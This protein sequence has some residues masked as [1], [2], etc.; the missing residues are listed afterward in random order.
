MNPHQAPFSSSARALPPHGRPARRAARARGRVRLLGTAT[1]LTVLWVTPALAHLSIIRQ[2]P[3]S[4]GSI[5]AG[6]RF[7]AALAAGDF[8]GDGFDDIAMGSPTEDV[9]ALADAGAVVV[10]YGAQYGI[11]HVGSQLFTPS[12]IGQTDQAGARFGAALATGDFNHDGYDDLVVGSPF[13]DVGGVADAGRIY[14]VYGSAGGLQSTSIV[15]DQTTGNG[16][17]ETGDHFG[18]SFAVG[19]FDGD[20]VGYDDLA[21]GAPGEDAGAGAVFVNYLG[22]FLGLTN[23][24]ATY[25]KQSSLGGTDSPGDQFGFAL[26]AGNLFGTSHDDLA[27]G[28][29]YKTI[30]V[31]GFGY[32]GAGAVWVLRGSDSGI[33]TSSPLTCDAATVGP[34]QNGANFGYALAVGQFFAGSTRS[35]AVAEPGRMVNGLAN[36]GRVLVVEG[37]ASALDWANARILT[38]DSGGAAVVQAGDRFGS[39]L[40]AGD[41]YDADGYDDLGIGSPDDGFGVTT[42]AGQFHIYPGGS[43]G[44]S[45]A[46]WSAFNQGTLNEP[47]EANDEF[48]AAVAYGHFDQGGRGGFAV[49]APGERYENPAEGATTYDDA[50]QVHMILPWRQTFGMNCLRSVVFDCENSM[51]FSQKPFERVRIAST[52]KAMTLLVAAERSQ[53]PPSDPDYVNLNV[54]YN[55][56][57]WV[58]QN[59]GGSQFG[60]ATGELMTI[61]DLLYACLY[62]SGNDAAY[63]IADACGMGATTDDRI[64]DFVGAMNARAASLG[65]T[66]THFNNPPGF[67]DEAYGPELGEHYSTAYDMAL[68]SRAV[69][70]NPLTKDISENVQHDI[71]RNIYYANSWLSFPWTIYNFFPGMNIPNATGIKGGFTNNAQITGLFSLRKGAGNPG[72]VLATTFTTPNGSSQYV[73][74]AHAL[75]NLG[76]AECS[77]IFALDPFNLPPFRIVTANLSTFDDFRRGFSANLPRDFTGDV[78][79]DVFRQSGDGPANASEELWRTSEVMLGPGESKP[80]GIMPFHEHHGFRILNMGTSPAMV[81]TQSSLSGASMDWTINEGEEIVVPAEMASPPVSEYQLMVENLDPTGA[82]EHLS[83]EEQYAFHLMDIPPVQVDPVFTAHLMR[84]GHIGDEGISWLHV[85]EDVATG[86]AGTTAPSGG[87]LLV[88]VHSQTVIVGVDETPSR[89]DQPLLR[90]L[91]ASPNPFGSRTRITFDLARSARVEAEMFDLLGRSVRKFAGGKLPAGRYGFEWNGRD[92]RGARLPQGVYLYRIRVEGETAARGKVVLER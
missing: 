49:G 47:F 52:T 77:A 53:L 13:E 12:A 79:F 21:I 42:A 46:G 38:Q 6:D 84:D 30:S 41:Y 35:L 58:A 62:R 89:D 76:A 68:L 11:T 72:D 39:A 29:P 90:L 32:P 5:E 69:R 23:G 10:S 36:A 25:V 56:P 88:G 3:E 37:G 71:I 80:F 66:G 75:L 8:N 40:A 61:H 63:A 24:I 19:N 83:V 48:G 7:G 9:G 44:P 26:A 78:V 15:W 33:S 31:L 22:G 4:R 92:A 67:E 91:G 43:T 70:L 57:S 86:P 60:L 45:G 2:G 1:L 85:G 87:N 17:N 34:P 81:R 73:S 27:I 50:G 51:I 64:A 59:I 16:T 28:A 54:Y 65:M 18:A 74:D 20:P 55:T 82:T 14:I